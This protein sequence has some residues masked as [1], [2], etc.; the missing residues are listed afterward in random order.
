MVIAYRNANTKYIEAA[1]SYL[2]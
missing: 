1:L 2:L